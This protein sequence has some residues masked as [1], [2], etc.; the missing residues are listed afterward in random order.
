[1]A[2]TTA[3]QAGNRSVQRGSIFEL[4]LAPPPAQ[5]AIAHILGTLDDRIELNRRVNE[6]PGEMARA[7]FKSWFVDF[8][9]VIDNALE[10]NPTPSAQ[11]KKIACGKEVCPRAKTQGMSAFLFDYACYSVSE[12][13]E[14]RRHGVVLRGMPGLGAA[15][16]YFLR[17]LEACHG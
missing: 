11:A 15:A 9:P 6:A 7:L 16:D 14:R 12:S 13:V 2:R 17:M 1:M 10:A 4:S 8:D 3:N 5:R